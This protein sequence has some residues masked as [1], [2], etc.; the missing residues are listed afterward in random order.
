MVCRGL[1]VLL[2]GLNEHRCV[3]YHCI[4]FLDLMQFYLISFLSKY[5]LSVLNVVVFLTVED[6][7]ILPRN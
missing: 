4:L 5:S 6:I 3:S 2:H 7:T 1:V